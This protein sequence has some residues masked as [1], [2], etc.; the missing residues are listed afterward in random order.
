MSVKLFARVKAKAGMEK[1]LEANY[2]EM[3][4]LVRANEPG[5]EAYILHRTNTDPT[6]FVWLEA[7]RDQAAFDLHRNAEHL[8][9]PRARN[10]SLVEAPPQIEFITE[11][12]RK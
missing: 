4:K 2:H 7:Y 9:A 6:L 12:D 1:E 3:I 5:C 11:L 10:A 8:K